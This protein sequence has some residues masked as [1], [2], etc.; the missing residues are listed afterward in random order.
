M[1]T[2]QEK[3]A[4]MQAHVDGKEIEF[5][6]FDKADVYSLCKAPLWDWYDFDYRIKPA[7]DDSID[8]S[9]IPDKYMYM[10]RDYNGKAYVFSGEP[11]MG[12]G[13][14]FPREAEFH[15]VDNIHKSYK[16]NGKDWNKSLVKRPS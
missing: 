4:V 5:K 1:T 16:N 14:W 9:Q 10:A 2:T 8:W 6:E 3:I 7:E 13:Q 11:V 12:T 15:Q